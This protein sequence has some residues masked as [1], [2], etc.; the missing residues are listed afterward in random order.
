MAARN[1]LSHLADSDDR[2]YVVGKTA[3]QWAQYACL[4]ATPIYAVQAVRHGAFSFH[5]LARYN[6]TIPLAG[7]ALGAG[8]STV[9]A[10]SK[11]AAT[12][13]EE[14][15]QLRYDRSRVRQEDYHLIGAA[16]GALVLPALLLRRVGLFNGALGGAG[17]GGAAGLG[18]NFAESLSGGA[19]TLSSKPAMQREAE[20]FGQQ[21]KDLG[22]RSLSKGKETLK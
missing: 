6:W 11:S 10:A 20:A 22:N 21:A 5:R 17:L 14:A 16:V 3:L 1:D 12:L 8:Y 15:T 7:G 18:Y 2:S 9:T 13:K 4:A 19:S